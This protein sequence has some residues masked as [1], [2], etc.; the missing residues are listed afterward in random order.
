MA[1]AVRNQ[2]LFVAEVIYFQG[3]G[4]ASDISIFLGCQW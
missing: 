4:E 3:L 2:L 1:S